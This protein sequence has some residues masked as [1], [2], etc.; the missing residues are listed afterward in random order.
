MD[1]R[2]TRTAFLLAFGL[3][4]AP[5][6]AADNE[7]NPNDPYE[8]Y[9]RAMH[10]FNNQADR[11]IMQP[12]AR[13]YRTVTPQPVRSAV[14]N[15]FNN[16]R[17]VVSFGSNLLRGNV[18]N[19][20]HDFMRV[21]INTTFGLGGLIDMAGYAQIPD[22]K[23]NL[24]DTF[25]SW[26]WKNSHYLVVPFLGPSTVRDTV[27]STV[28]TVYSPN[29]LI[30]DKIFRYSSTAL[31]AVNKREQLLDTTDAFAKMRAPDEYAYMRDFYM[32]LRNKQVGNKKAADNA[33]DVNLDE[34]L[35][36]E[37]PDATNATENPSAPEN[38][39]TAPEQ[40]APQQSS[41]AEPLYP[42]AWEQE[43]ADRF[44]ALDDA[45]PAAIDRYI[46]SQAE[47]TV[48]AQP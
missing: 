14:S 43:E 28:T 20:G 9:N 31:N 26:G 27:G 38:H 6:V 23:N 34:L 21:A 40:A 12:V 44:T 32:S 45:E 35:N 13:T 7:R 4:I 46:P 47:Q 3:S 24:G 36:S 19:A 22:N 11:Y 8:P 15:F 5:A 29:S 10:A 39:N 41:S 1:S 25:A 18:E 33:D 48:F 37:A 30:N 42:A 17:D 16:L 2:H